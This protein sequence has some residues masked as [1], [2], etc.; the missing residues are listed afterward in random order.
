MF[1][2]P[3]AVWQLFVLVT[4]IGGFS[5]ALGFDDGMGSEGVNWGEGFEGLG[6]EKMV[7]S[8]YG[9]RKELD[10][11][12]PV[13]AV[14]LE[15]D[16]GL[17]KRIQKDKTLKIPPAF[18]GEGRAS[19][20]S[21]GHPEIC[22][23]LT[24]RCL[25]TVHS[26]AGVYCCSSTS[27][28]CIDHDLSCPSSTYSCTPENSGGCCPLGTICAPD[29]CIPLPDVVRY[30]SLI[31]AGA[32]VLRAGEHTP[33]ATN[34]LAVKRDIGSLPQELHNQ[35]RQ[36]N[37]NE[38]PVYDPLLPNTLPLD[39]IVVTTLPAFPPTTNPPQPI[40][41]PAPPPRRPTSD[42]DGDGLSGTQDPTEAPANG[43]FQ[44]QP[45]TRT[46]KVEDPAIYSRT[47]T[48]GVRLAGDITKGAERDEDGRLRQGMA[49]MFDNVNESF[50]AAAPGGREKVG[51]CLGARVEVMVMVA[52]VVG[53]VGVVL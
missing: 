9:E 5:L 46:I 21:L 17:K 38:G 28:E 32:T 30:S 15:M 13:K 2:S 51:M 43:G 3:C 25:P 1:R 53:V 20:A 14:M 48:S 6:I 36:E 52:A 19:C 33:A 37:D 42:L 12:L 10:A 41:T 50:L 34:N 40:I 45:T 47:Q 44:V 7:V 11:A 23:P 35:K 49:I 16:C 24:S 29:R 27:S 8:G 39:I 22:C 18:C 31:Q 26:L 4:Y